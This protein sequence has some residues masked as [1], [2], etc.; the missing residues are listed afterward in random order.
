MLF[1]AM[2]R[3]SLNKDEKNET[4]ISVRVR[5]SISRT[6]CHLI[7]YRPGHDLINHG[8]QVLWGVGDAGAI[9]YCSRAK[10][11]FGCH[12]SFVYW[13]I[14][15][16]TTDDRICTCYWRRSVGSLEFFGPPVALR[17]PLICH[18]HTTGRLPARSW[19]FCFFPSTYAN[20]D[21]FRV[22]KDFLSND[23]HSELPTYVGIHSRS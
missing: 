11:L 19:N 6:I 15:L 23:P 8:A 7:T 2:H 14:E 9:R 22:R 5:R 18:K 1:N 17:S 20:Y 12:R 10:T 13:R 21:G 4:I 3:R 16:S